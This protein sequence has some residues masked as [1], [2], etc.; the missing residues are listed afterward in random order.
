MLRQHARR[1]API[2]VSLAALTWFVFAL[3]EPET[4]RPPPASYVP[5]AVGDATFR[6]PPAWREARRTI[7]GVELRGPGAAYAELRWLDEG[8]GALLRATRR[9]AALRGGRETASRSLALD[10]PGSAGSG[11]DEL[12]YERSGG[13]AFRVVMTRAYTPA[14]RLVVLTVRGRATGDRTDPRHVAGSLRLR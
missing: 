10:V 12:V 13:R 4:F 1:L 8:R 6:A 3:L 9:M 7:D 5:R 2:L 14:G 11:V